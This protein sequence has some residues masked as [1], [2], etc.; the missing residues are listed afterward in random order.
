MIPYFNI[1]FGIQNSLA[2]AK[3][4]RVNAIKLKEINFGWTNRDQLGQYLS[5]YSNNST[6][7]IPAAKIHKLA[8]TTIG[9]Y[10]EHPLYKTQ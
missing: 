2:E 1:S 6:V 7:Y 5:F 3:T 4:K 9:F 10:Q 8:K